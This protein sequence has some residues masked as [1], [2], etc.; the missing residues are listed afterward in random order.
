M[1]NA[2][3]HWTIYLVASQSPTPPPETGIPGA[4]N[5]SV[6]ILFLVLFSLPFSLDFL[7]SSSLG[8]PPLTSH[9]ILSTFYTV[10]LGVLI[11]LCTNNKRQLSTEYIFSAFRSPF[12]INT[13][14]SSTYPL[15]SPLL[16]Q[17]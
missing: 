9:I 16:F 10:V 17:C 2:E 14:P 8:V 5:Y 12:D 4:I 6:H 1:Q 7:F 15:S 3:V 11:F 13:I